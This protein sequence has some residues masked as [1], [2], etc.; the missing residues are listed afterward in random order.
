MFK[1]LHGVRGQNSE[2]LLESS[3]LFWRNTNKYF[4]VGLQEA[5][6]VGQF[7][8]ILP[9]MIVLH[10]GSNI[11]DVNKTVFNAR[12]LVATRIRW[13]RRWMVEDREPLTAGQSHHLNQD[14]RPDISHFCQVA[15]IDLTQLAET[16]PSSEKRAS[17]DMY[18]G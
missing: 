3:H 2:A 4:V 14:Q 9:G 10:I 5:K 17:V 7:K 11:I 13:A 18:E 8:V 12:I 6:D 15:R 1:S 16:A